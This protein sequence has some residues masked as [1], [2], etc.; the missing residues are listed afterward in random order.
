MQVLHFQAYSEFKLYNLITQRAIIKTGNFKQEQRL[1]KF[2]RDDLLSNGGK[3]LYRNEIYF[4]E[5]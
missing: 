5:C 2:Y 3:F 1:C 4:M